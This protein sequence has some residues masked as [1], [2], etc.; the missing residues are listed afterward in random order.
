MRRSGNLSTGDAEGGD[1]LGVAAAVAAALKSTLA[2]AEEGM[3]G[4][5]AAGREAGGT[6]RGCDALTV[7]APLGISNQFFKVLQVTAVHVRAPFELALFRI[8]SLDRAL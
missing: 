2:G 5:D 1:G 8:F 4:V 7:D 6:S 3:G